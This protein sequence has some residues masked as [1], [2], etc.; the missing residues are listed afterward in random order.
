MTKRMADYKWRDINEWMRMT[1]AGELAL[2]DFQRSWVWNPKR[3]K[4]Y[5]KA[6]IENRPTGTFLILETADRPQFASRR[7]NGVTDAAGEAIELV[8]DGQQRLTALWK[9]LGGEK[10]PEHR[11]YLEV[12]NLKERGMDVIDVVWYSSKTRLGRS[13]VSPLF[14][15]NKGLIP[16]SILSNAEDEYEWGEIWHWCNQACGNGKAAE[17]KPLEQEIRRLR[18]QLLFSRQLWYCRLDKNTEASEAVEIFI[19]TNSSSVAV[20]QVDI[21]I[22]LAKDKYDENLRGRIYDAFQRNKIMA[23]YFKTDPEEWIPSTG[24]WMLKVACLRAGLAPK[25]ANYDEALRKMVEGRTFEVLDELF[26]NLG[27]TLVMAAREGAPTMR[28]VPSQPPLHV[29]AALQEK[30]ATFRDPTK[31]G[32]CD[33]LVR[34]YYWRCLFSNRH[35]AQANDRLLEDYSDLATYLEEIEAYGRIRGSLRGAF[36]DNAHPIPTADDLVQGL[37]WIASGRRGR[38][39][40][41]LVTRRRPADWMT[42]QKFDEERIRELENRRNL[43]RHHVFPQEVLKQEGIGKAS[44]QHGLNGV[45]LNK[46]T[47]LRLSKLDPADYFRDILEQT[48]ENKLR[49]RVSSHLIPYDEIMGGEGSV[50]ERYSAY[51]VGRAKLVSEEIRRLVTV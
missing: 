36:D 38:A 50:R 25:K 31:I 39:L 5:L 16:I 34:A 12:S 47:N 21:V 17:V 35:E 42:G 30:L 48:T 26:E 44:V 37:P 14:A 6:L 33:E 8:L 15:Y 46:G 43:D 19:E 29:I 9:A 28:M 18:E 45:L 32:K 23:H 1:R 20:K 49:A 3:I 4:L 7:I 22:A 41:A 24:E 27:E 10:N 2:P 11:F 40:A 51:L 13:L